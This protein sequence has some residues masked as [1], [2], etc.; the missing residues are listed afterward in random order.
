MARH[1]AK[2]SVR[3]AQKNLNILTVQLQCTVL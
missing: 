3:V 2:S 1:G